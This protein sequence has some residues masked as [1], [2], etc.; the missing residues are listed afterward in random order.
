MRY[1]KV[2]C[3][4]CHNIFEDGDDIVVCPECGMPHHREC[5][6]TLGHCAMSDQ[7]AQGFSFVNPNLH[8][9]GRI[10]VPGIINEN[11]TAAQSGSTASPA[12]P[13]QELGGSIEQ[14]GQDERD[15]QRPGMRPIN[16]DDPIDEDLTASDYGDLVGKNK[17][18]YIPQFLLMAKTGHKVSW[19]WAAFFF[20]Y[21]W[22]FYR[23][24]YK[25]GIICA[26]I[27]LI[28]PV[29][30]AKD[31]A[32]YEQKYISVYSQI[33]AGK[34]TAEEGQKALPVETP[35]L[36]IYS[37]VQF[38]VMFAAGM[39]GNYWYKVCC[40]RKLLKLKKKYS[41][42]EEYEKAV[43]KNS[44]TS[45]FMMIIAFI[46]VEAITYGCVSLAMTYDTDLAI[47]IVSLIKK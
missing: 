17:K 14:S 8:D 4:V 20:P 34:M 24:M 45:V 5:Y 38:A 41:S 32:D 43:E 46:A 7:H 3:P 33:S 2:E 21:M 35:A 13:S 31:Y 40:R 42:A 12:A 16:A 6:K 22:M 10:R 18:K 44:G 37:Y 47:K 27:L 11:G 19:N 15:R 26:V 9:E 30:F 36:R 28:I 23:K 29:F 39:F 25:A 1:D